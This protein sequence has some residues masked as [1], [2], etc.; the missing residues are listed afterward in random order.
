[1]VNFFQTRMGQT[2][3]EHHVPEM[4]KY[5]ENIAHELRRANM[6]K[7][8]ELKMKEEELRLLNMKLN[9]K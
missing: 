9:Q 7:E 6:L 5:V 4:V 1:M 8:K 3:Y 2:Y